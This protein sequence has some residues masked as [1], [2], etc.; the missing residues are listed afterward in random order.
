MGKI[1]KNFKKYVIFRTDFGHFGL[2]AEQ[3]HLTKT[4]LPQP[5]PEK[6]KAIFLADSPDAKYEKTLFHQL[7]VQIT[8]YFKGSYVEFNKDIPIMIAPATNFTRRVL[9]ACRNITYGQTISYS[10]LARKSGSPA[11]ARAVGSILSK[12]PLPLIIP[13]HRI[14]KADGGIGKFSA[15]GGTKTKIKLLNLEQKNRFSSRC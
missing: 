14:I 15:A 6:I 12:N 11:A 4:V 13:C 8:A 3:N 1:S 9:T 2:A 5:D 10:Q 7:Q